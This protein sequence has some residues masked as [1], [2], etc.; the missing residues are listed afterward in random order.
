[1]G[2]EIEDLHKLQVYLNSTRFYKYRKAENINKKKVFNKTNSTFFGLR[3]S[4]KR[5]E[6]VKI[7]V[8]H[9]EFWFENK[10]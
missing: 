10:L 3:E 4:S 7:F 8:F 2:S 6:I 9:R 5:E 1:M